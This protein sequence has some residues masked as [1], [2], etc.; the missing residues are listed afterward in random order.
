[1]PGILSVIHVPASVNLTTRRVVLYVTRDYARVCVQ[2]VSRT[3]QEAPN[4]TYILLPHSTSRLRESIYNVSSGRINSP[5]PVYE[6]WDLVTVKYYFQLRIS[7]VS[8]TA[9]VC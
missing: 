1:L 4:I 9:I 5:L 6:I 3:R 2:A 7:I 8:N